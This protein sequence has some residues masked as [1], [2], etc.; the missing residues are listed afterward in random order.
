MSDWANTDPRAVGA[1]LARALALPALLLG[2]LEVWARTVG[3][4]SDALAAPSAAAWALVRAAGF[5]VEYSRP[6]YVHRLLLEEV[7]PYRWLY[8]RGGSAA[9]RNWVRRLGGG[10]DGHM[11]LLVAH[12]PAGKSAA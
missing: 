9:W 1:R 8:D 6:L 12:K 11:L 4:H 3:Q 2:M 5:E 10:R 7:G